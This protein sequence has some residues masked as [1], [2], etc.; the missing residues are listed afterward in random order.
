MTTTQAVIGSAVAAGL[1]V[2]ALAKPTKTWVSGLLTRDKQGRI[3]LVLTPA[4]RK[5]R[6]KGK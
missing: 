3:A 2:A 5:R 1:I 4:K 6:K